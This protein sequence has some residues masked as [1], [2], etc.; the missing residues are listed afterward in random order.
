MDNVD[1]IVIS[2]SKFVGDSIS[3]NNAEDVTI[4]NVSFQDNAISGDSII[5]IS[6]AII[7]VSMLSLL[8]TI[9]HERQPQESHIDTYITATV[10]MLFVI[11][12]LI[13]K[14]S[15]AKFISESNSSHYVGI[16]EIT[17]VTSLLFLF[18]L[19]GLISL[20]SR[21]IR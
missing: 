1:N 21:K 14:H 11:S 12:L 7:Y 5:S 16:A 3:I 6:I 13:Y 8:L 20:N 15:S 19:S 4:S 10:I 17:L 2:D 9:T 18:V